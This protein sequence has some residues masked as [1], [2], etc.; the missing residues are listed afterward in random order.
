MTQG[1]LIGEVVRRI[2]GTTIGTWFA[3]EVAGPLG[4]DFHIGLPESEDHRVSMVIPPPPLDL[5]ALKP[6]ELVIRAMTNPLL[7]ATYPSHGL[8]APGRDPGGQRA[9]QRPVGGPG[10]VDHRRRGARPG[11][12]GSCRRPGA[13]GSSTSRSTAPT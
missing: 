9:R 8:V 11:A 2:T 7:D 12:C 5:E 3:S 4:A 1:Y 10:A 6:S 13:T